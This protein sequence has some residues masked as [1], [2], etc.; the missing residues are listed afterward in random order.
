ME[1]P[2][3]Y[4][5]TVY[6]PELTLNGWKVKSGVLLGQYF[7]GF[8]HKY[9]VTDGVIS[10]T[11]VKHINYYYPSRKEAWASVAEEEE[12]KILKGRK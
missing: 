5:T 11:T 7:T 8:E 10:S 4:R 9:I 2:R 12:V 6:W 3:Y 1:A